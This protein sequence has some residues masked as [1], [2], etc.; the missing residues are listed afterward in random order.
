MLLFPADIQADFC[1]CTGKSPPKGKSI[2]DY[3]ADEIMIFADIMN[4]LSRKLLGYHTP[5]ELFDAE[6]DRIYA[7]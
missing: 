1:A 5:E 3:S 2:D 7:V 6:L 4:A